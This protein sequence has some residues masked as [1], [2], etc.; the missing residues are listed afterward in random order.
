MKKEMNSRD[1][2]VREN[3]R[4]LM[5]HEL[6]GNAREPPEKPTCTEYPECEGCPYP[7]H[8]FVCWPGNCMKKQMET[9]T[10]VRPVLPPAAMPAAL[11]M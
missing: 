4:Q 2:P 9:V 11:S 1:H 5:R 10:A 3:Y 6:K 7:A 8:G